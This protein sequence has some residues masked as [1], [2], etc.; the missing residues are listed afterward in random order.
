MGH[1]YEADFVRDKAFAWLILA[2]MGLSG[3]IPGRRLPRRLPAPEVCAQ[4]FGQL[5]L[6]AFGFCE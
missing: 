3:G 5:R 6:P 2:L 4:R 1:G